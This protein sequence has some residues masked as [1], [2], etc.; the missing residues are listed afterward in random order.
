M[1]GP[2]TRAKP[3]VVAAA[4][5]GVLKVHEIPALQE[6]VEAYE[7]ATE[8]RGEVGAAQEAAGEVEADRNLRL[9]ENA[10]SL[11]YYNHT[12]RLRSLRVRS[13]D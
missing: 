4:L 8:V 11:S 9:G 6:L 13:S 7:E 5:R 1:H 10:W 12:L 2:V 3:E